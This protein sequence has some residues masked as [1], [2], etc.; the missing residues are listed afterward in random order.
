MGQRDFERSVR[1]E[2]AVLYRVARRLGADT[3]TAEDVVQ[4]ALIKA[5]QAWDRFDGRYIRS[6]LITILRNEWYMSRRSARHEASLDDHD[7]PEIPD[8]PFWDTL[9]W[10]LDADKVLMELGGLPDI[11]QMAIQLCDVEQ[12]TYEEAAEAMEVPVGTVRSRLFRARVM[13]R[14]RLVGTI[15][16]TEDQNR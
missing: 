11:Y 16:G 7:A 2:L 5:F 10:K 14:S 3:D 1:G 15:A 4:S 12:M 8:K 13:L 6:W 9:N